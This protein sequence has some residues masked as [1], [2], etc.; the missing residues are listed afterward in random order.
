MTQRT[1]AAVLAVPVVIAL[2]VAVAFTGLPYATYAPGPTID[3]LGISGD[4]VGGS[5]DGEIISV[6]GA[7]A[8]YDDSGQ[9]RMTTVS[10][11][12]TDRQMPL[13]ELLW[14]WFD[15]S[16][17]VYPYDYVH[18]DD[19][20]AEEEEQ[21]GAIQ[22]VT[23]QDV[24]VAVAEEALGYDVSPVL[25]V[26]LV[27]DG[28]P[29]DGVLKVRDLV[30]R[31]NGEKVT[32]TQM[33]VRTIRRSG[34]DPV[35]L[36][37]QRN[38]KRRTVTITPEKGDDGVYRVGFTPGTG[39]EFPV[40]VSIDIDSSIGGPSAGLMFS[41]AVYDTLTEE[42]VTGGHVIAGTGTMSEDG[43][44]GPIGGIQ[45]KIAGAERDGAEVFLVPADNCA[46]AL[47]VDDGSPTLLRADDF[48]SALAAVQDW[49]ADPDDPDLPTCSNQ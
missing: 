1:L 8:Y 44:V 25:M 32:G 34:G 11:S 33:L 39:Y 27:Q 28:S 5:G 3:V 19:T 47:E 9:L 21:K 6:D 36:V 31:I 37:L 48:D 49:V 7:K 40:Q 30:L 42:S 18:P 23:S 10:V 16:E 46:E 24:A 29:A 41:L 12:A 2:L 45:Q 38:G 14:A 17:A 43:A 13:P 4:A 15:P 35:T 20:T 22:M 26:A